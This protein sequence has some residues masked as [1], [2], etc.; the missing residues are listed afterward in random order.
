MSTVSGLEG[1]CENPECLHPLG[2][3]D[4]KK[5]AARRC[6]FDWYRCT[7][8]VECNGVYYRVSWPLA[9]E[10]TSNQDPKNTN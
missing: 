10:A 8:P 6:R 9:W 5:C 3:H 2:I 1:W 7:V 4:K